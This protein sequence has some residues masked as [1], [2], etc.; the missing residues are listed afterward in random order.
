MNFPDRPKLARRDGESLIAVRYP[1][2]YVAEETTGPQRLRIG[3]ASEPV[4]VLLSL[5]ELWERDYFLLYVLIVP[6]GSAPEAGRYQSPGPLSFDD[7]AA[8]CRRFAPFLEGDARHHLW[9]GSTGQAGHLIYDHHE[10]IYA[11]GDLAG[12]EALLLERGFQQGEI[13][14][15]VP[16]THNFL[17]EFDADEEALMAYWP[18]AHCPLQPGDDP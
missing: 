8:F 13:E 2:V 16:H 4:E 3:P 12:Y 7:V 14:L 11:Y 5:A 17:Q 10:W 9:I 15:P 1:N 18:W 6:R